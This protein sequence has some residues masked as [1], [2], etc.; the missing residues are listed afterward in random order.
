MRDNFSDMEHLHGKKAA[1]EARQMAGDVIPIRPIL[2][3]STTAA[4][5]GQAQNKGA[6]S[7]NTGSKDNN[8]YG[9]YG[10]IIT[11]D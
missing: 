7:P 5:A 4:R 11:K 9:L 6:Q 8:I 1:D 2:S 10:H 3:P